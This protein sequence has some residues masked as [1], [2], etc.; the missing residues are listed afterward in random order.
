[1]ERLIRYF[2]LL[3]IILLLITGVLLFKESNPEWKL[4]QEEYR[5]HLYS[6]AETPVAKDRVS[7]FD[8]GVKQ[9]WI[10][11]LDEADR[12]RS[13]HIGVDNP[14]APSKAP[15]APHPDITPHSFDKFGCTVC[16]EGDG[17]ATR[18]PDAHNRLLPIQLIE[19]SCGKC[20]GL[21]GPGTGEAPTYTAG[22]RLLQ[23]KTCTGCHLVSGEKKSDF[24]GPN[25]LGINS[26]VSRKWLVKWLKDPRNYL[27]ASRMADC[28]L[29]EDEIYALADF[30]LSQDLPKETADIFYE[31]KGAEQKIV[32]SMSD[33]ELDEL[34]DQGKI[35]FGRLRCLSC[36]TL[37]GKGGNIGPEL[38]R[39]SQKASRAWLSAWIRSPS[40]YNVHT[41]MPTFNM[42]ITERL[43]LIEYLL[44]ESEVE[45]FDEDEEPEVNITASTVTQSVKGQLNGRDIFLE[46]G[47]V[48]CHQLPE[49]KANPEFAPP[50]KALA[51]KKIEKIDFGKTD[52]PRT[53]PD[54]IAVKLQNPRAYSDKLKMPDFGFSPEETGRLATVLLGRSNLIPSS[55]KMPKQATNLAPLT[56]EVGRIFER[57]KCLTCHK[58]GEQ[59][60]TL[61]PD[62]AFE[63]SKVQK[64]WLKGYLEK[65]YAIRPYLVERMPRFN[66]TPQEADR[67]AEYTDLVLRNDEIDAA[68]KPHT[69]DPDV[70]R[71]L[72]F[73]KYVCQ[74]C[75]SIN[76]EGGYYGPALENVAKR[77]KHTWINIRLVNPHPFEP[78]ARE[79]ALS[80]PDEERKNILAFLDT[81]E[82]EEQP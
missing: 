24:H 60:G 28:L 73:E 68:S 29:K 82:A 1:M 74:S 59:G 11:G 13:C 78:G 75:H 9:D 23:D 20:H 63:G 70:G 69:G 16:H 12:C 33:D 32:N 18:L 25:L 37:N 80:I 42:S 4:Y 8:I 40:T 5:E 7:Q 21:G 31:E 53:L 3:S 64:E 43:G 41:V 52:I 46:K 34:V 35:I 57:Y 30:L 6:Q 22:Y 61:A 54:Y 17:L 36:H 71:L 15:L 2:F 47:C 44:W 50:L 49:I 56:G 77:L 67:I 58:L 38:S 26:K 27:P 45:E 65:P 72:Y 51:D 55:Y 39:I 10:S 66:M 79:P 62:L 19:A 76:G 48:N 14:D 81:L